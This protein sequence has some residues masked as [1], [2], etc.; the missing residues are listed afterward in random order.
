MTAG[1]RKIASFRVVD[2]KI[3]FMTMMLCGGRLAKYLANA[4]EIVLELAA[5]VRDILF[6]FEVGEEPVED[7]GVAPGRE[8]AAR[9]AS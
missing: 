9:L 1:P 8:R 4:D 3:S 7:E 2:V 5:Q 6:P